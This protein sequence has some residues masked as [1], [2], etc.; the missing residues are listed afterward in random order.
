MKQQNQANNL[1]VAMLWRG[2]AQRIE[3]P[4]QQNNRLY[5]LFKAFA[6]LNVTAEP[7]P[8]SDNALDHVWTRLLQLDGVLVWVDPVTEYGD[9]SKLDPMLKDIAARGVWVSAHPDIIQKIGTKEVLFRTKHFSWG[10][11]THLYANEEQF[12]KD[13]PARLRSSGPRVLKQRRGNGGIGTWRVEIVHD[14][15]NP[16]VRTQEARRGSAEEDLRLN[17]FF[18]KCAKYFSA[19]G[20]I[21]DQPL[22]PRIGEGMIRCYLVQDKVVGFSTQMP[23]AKGDFAMARDKT[24]YAEDERRFAKLRANMESD[25]APSVQRLFGIDSNA[26]PAIWDADFMYGP[27]DARGDDTYVLGEINVSAVFP[28]PDCAIEKIAKAAAIRLAEARRQ[29]RP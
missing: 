27:E 19:C 6:D 22:D 21:L 18:D 28:F 13:F 12:R 20:C 9:R 1:R 8:Y 16:M 25:W 7:V 11:D 29:Q 5:P 4:T 23:R 10:T 14:E 17:E 15:A 2:D 3:A 24:M 26:L